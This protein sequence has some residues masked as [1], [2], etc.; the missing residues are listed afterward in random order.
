MGMANLRCGK[1]MTLISCFLC[2]CQVE[3]SVSETCPTASTIHSVD[4]ASGFCVAKNITWANDRFG[5]VNQM[6]R[7]KAKSVRSDLLW[8]VV[9]PQAD[10]W[11]WAVADDMVAAA[12]DNDLEF[13]PMLGYGVPWASDQTDSDPYFPPDDPNDFALFAGRV[14]DR[15][16]GVVR[17]YEIW[18]EPNAGYRFWKPNFAGDGVAYG[19]LF[20]AAEAAIH[21]VDPDAEVIVGG[22]FFHEQA[23]PGT[24]SFIDEMLSAHPS[25]LAKADGVAVHPYTL[26]PPRV[27]PEESGDGEV[28]V[29]EMIEQLRALTGDLPIL[30]TEMGW[31]SLGEVTEK[32]QADWLIRE[33]LLLQAQGISDVCWYT[34]SDDEDPSNPEQAF[35]LTDFDGNLKP[36][37]AAYLEL[38]ELAEQAT[39]VGQI[40]NLPDGTWGVTYQGV[41][42]AFWGSGSVCG[43]TLSE[44]PVWIK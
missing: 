3:K 19:E 43:E 37:G 15:Y 12:V 13:I 24:L 11:D 41:G 32:D 9:Q 16:K 44:T 25:I 10:T 22:T 14:A 23:I 28:P 33:F 8:H 27:A 2:G 18:N 29:W 7:L 40:E 17:R 35:G 31:P 38:A 21:A 30:V 34:L 20:L 6:S 5:V 26:Y 1:T 4:L 36:S 42:S 39:G